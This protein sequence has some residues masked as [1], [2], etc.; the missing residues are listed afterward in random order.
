LFF[1]FI[2]TYWSERIRTVQILYW[3]VQEPRSYYRYVSCVRNVKLMWIGTFLSFFEW[4]GLD[5]YF[6]FYLF[7]FLRFFT[8]DFLPVWLIDNQW[9]SKLVAKDLR[10]ASC[11][12]QWC[13][14]NCYM[15]DVMKITLDINV[16]IIYNIWRLSKRHC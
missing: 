1:I 5:L 9:S 10:W 6:V 11:T 2:V 7:D 3:Y 15:I 14:L 12:C 13:V 16:C 8:L 4:F